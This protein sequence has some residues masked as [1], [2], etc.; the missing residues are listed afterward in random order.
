MNPKYKKILYR[1]HHQ[2]SKRKHMSLQ[3]RAAQFSPFAALV[4]YE[5][6]I[7]DT[8]RFHQE[9][10]ELGESD[11]EELNTKINILISNLKDHPFIDIV[12]YHPQNEKYEGKSGNVLRIDEIHK[13]LL[14]KDGTKI[15]LDSI[16]Q[17]DIK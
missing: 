9:K 4:G 5:D 1:K 13:V 10:I 14:F 8:N 2:S 7:E 11:L 6:Q 12:Y 15:E 3:E 16:L 17:I